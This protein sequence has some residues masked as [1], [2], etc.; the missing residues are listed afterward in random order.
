VVV[1]EKL[2]GNSLEHC[3]ESLSMQTQFGFKCPHGPFIIE[4]V[5]AAYK[6][7]RIVGSGNSAHTILSY[8]SAF[9]GHKSGNL[10]GKIG[11]AIRVIIGKPQGQCDMHTLT[12]PS[13]DLI[14]NP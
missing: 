11:K 1:L 13:G 6:L 3:L 4:V 2:F 10:I 8:M 12:L 9:Q 5:T 7:G 14:V